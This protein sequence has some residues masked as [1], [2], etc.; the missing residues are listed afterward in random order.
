MT[1]KGFEALREQYAHL[2]Y[3]MED[4][5]FQLKKAYDDNEKLKNDI[6][7]QFQK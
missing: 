5:E 2:K 4:K 3:L 1:E 7:S 6:R